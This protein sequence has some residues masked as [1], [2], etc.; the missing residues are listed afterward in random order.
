MEVVWFVCGLFSYYL[1][2]VAVMLSLWVRSTDAPFTFD[3]LVFLCVF[4]P[5]WP[6]FAVMELVH[7]Y[8]RG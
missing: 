8:R 2:G 6:L 7:W 3:V 1:L 4:A 5:I